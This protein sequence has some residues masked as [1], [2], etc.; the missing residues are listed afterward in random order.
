M[1]K[2]VVETRLVSKLPELRRQFPRLAIGVCDGPLAGK[3]FVQAGM[4]C[5]VIGSRS[6]G[7]ADILRYTDWTDLAESGLP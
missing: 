6:V 1:P 5:V 7:Q 3:A 4:R 2:V